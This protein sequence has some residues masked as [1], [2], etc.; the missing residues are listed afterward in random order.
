MKKSKEFWNKEYANVRNFESS[1][2]WKP[3]SELLELET[4][5]K[6]HQIPAKGWQAL[7]LACGNGRNSI[8]MLQNW[9]VANAIG[10]DFAQVPLAHFKS[11]ATE[12]GL[13]SR[14]KI[15]EQ[16]IGKTFPI[17]D[18]SIDLALDIYGSIN[19]RADERTNCKDETY[20]VLKRGGLLLTYLTSRDSGFV[21]QM[22]DCIQ[23]P[24]PDSVIFNNGK[25]E[26]VFSE[27]EIK[28]FYQDFELVE[29]RRHNFVV[30]KYPVEMFWVVLRK[31]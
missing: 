12:E 17:P 21:K 8:Y 15:F 29:L 3:S 6:R 2:S 22:I 10:I 7:D 26:K 5:L 30:D 9:D 27:E 18:E 11:K 13:T 28:T 4:Y 16:S 24:E 19:L 20:R 1:R 14:V 23:G 25:F 31:T